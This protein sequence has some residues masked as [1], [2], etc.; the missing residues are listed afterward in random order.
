MRSACRRQPTAAALALTLGFLALAAIALGAC[1][2]D[3]QPS[4][5]AFC[6]RLEFAYGPEGALASDYSD[7]PS[8]SQAV[9]DELEAIRQ[10]APLE[11][12]PSLVT[13][14]DIARLII[15][16]IDNPEDSRL[17]AEQLS[18]SAIAAA[19]LARYSADRCG[20]ALDW[21]SP[22]VFV[23]PDRIPGEVDLDVR[24]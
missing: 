21:E 9:I 22:A 11:M 10:V 24:G 7:D 19:E 14:I 20:L 3:D 5:D 23:D 18:Q 8:G 1:G 17:S 15:A 6:E 13:I 16:A 12:E 2:D 4:L